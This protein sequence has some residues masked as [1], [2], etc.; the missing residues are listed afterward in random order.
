MTKDL[1]VQNS[2]F[3]K[4]EVDY[5]RPPAPL[6]I[7]GRGYVGGKAVG[8]MYAA[9]QFDTPAWK[10]LPHTD[11]VQ[12][13]VTTVLTSEFFDRFLDF[14][15]LAGAYAELDYLDLV[16]RYL[17]ARFPDSD[18]KLFSSLL[19]RMDYPLAIRSSSLLEDN[20][21]YSFAGIYLTLFIPNTGPPDVRLDHFESAVK[22]V[23][24]S[25]Y[26]PNAHA[27][28]RH[29][30]LRGR[31]EKMSILVQRMIGKRHGDL[32]YP[33]MA[34]VAFSHNYFPWTSRIKAEDGLVR[35]VFGLGTR[36]VGRNYA[37]VFSPTQPMLRP[38]GSVVD[39]IVRY[40]QDYF[41]AV[42]LISA[43][44]VSPAVTD[45]VHNNPEWS[46]V[47]SVLVGEELLQEPSPLGLRPGERPVVTFR[48]ILR[49]DQYM[50]LV[51][52]IRAVLGGLQE[53]FGLPVDVEFACTFEGE[54]HRPVFY[55][56]QCRPLG[57]RA[58]HQHVQLPDLEGRT[59]VFSGGRCMGN[60]H[61]D[62]IRHLIYVSPQIW[63][64][65]PAREL[66]RS[67]GRLCH[68]LEGA[69]FILAGPGRWGTNNPELGVPV[70]YGEIA[71]AAVLVEVAAGRGTPE[72]SYGT[73]FFG[74]LVAQDT[75]YMP[76]FP[77]M[78]DRTDEAWLEAQPNVG[79]EQWVKLISPPA[80]FIVTFD[81]Q[82]REAAVYLGEELGSEAN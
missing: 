15:G 55:L 81:G 37:R 26:N 41:D 69:P 70:D 80:G 59:V 66:A 17:Q 20:V 21:N 44:L 74:D 68:S 71:G 14:N 34:G 45:A 31:D 62:D 53:S 30:Q 75:Y 19:A 6:S 43:R 11:L 40:S 7:C 64:A 32:F 2:P 24:A 65:V 10:G 38:E 27:Y 50:P 57:A 58:K 79:P 29:H 51:P 76:V 61:R 52:L 39:Q 54:D 49:D 72:L 33:P 18:R 5:E 16:A 23:F 9:A 4:Y 35:L 46:K 47:C 48:S 25:T 77:E 8:L 13:P 63:S 67:V 3:L 78:G 42:D 82:T 60:G 73:H 28:R 22:R 56:L 12:V 36:A 1:G